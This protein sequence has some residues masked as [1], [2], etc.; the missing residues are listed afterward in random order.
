[1]D[2]PEIA[3]VLGKQVAL[4]VPLHCPACSREPPGSKQLLSS[5]GNHEESLFCPHCDLEVNL[6]VTSVKERKK[7]ADKE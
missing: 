4:G 5:V 2:K 1:M 7:D 6:V 3:K